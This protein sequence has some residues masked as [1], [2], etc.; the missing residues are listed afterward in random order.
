MKFAVLFLFFL[1]IMVDSQMVPVPDPS[2]KEPE[3]D[4]FKMEENQKFLKDTILKL[5]SIGLAQILQ[6]FPQVVVYFREK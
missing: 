4:P 3:T 2:E 1:F 6:A 5:D